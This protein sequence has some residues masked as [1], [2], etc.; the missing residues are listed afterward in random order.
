[1]YTLYIYNYYISDC[2]N[3]YTIYTIHI[4]CTLFCNMYLYST[5]YIHC[6]YLFLILYSLIYNQHIY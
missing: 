5:H 4:L 1:M 2:N 6:L 3:I